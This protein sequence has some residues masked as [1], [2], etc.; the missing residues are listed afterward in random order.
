MAWILFSELIAVLKEHPQYYERW[1]LEVPAEQA[2]YIQFSPEKM[3]GLESEVL[4]VVDG[5]ELVID[6]GKDG[7][8]Y[9]IEIT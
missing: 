7:K 5:S 4:E 3:T 9:G 1:E 8:V 2:L 6:R